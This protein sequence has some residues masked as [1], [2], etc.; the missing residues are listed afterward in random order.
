M[1]RSPSLRE[2]LP[3]LA[4]R[5]FTGTFLEKLSQSRFKNGQY[6]PDSAMDLEFSGHQSDPSLN[7]RSSAVL[8]QYGAPR[9]RPNLDHSEPP[10]FQVHG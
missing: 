3:A 8:R 4:G 2:E 5:V 9:D 7:D 1:A 6:I 10:K